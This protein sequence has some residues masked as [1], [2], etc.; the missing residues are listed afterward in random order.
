MKAEK[1]GVSICTARL[2]EP[3]RGSEVV[4]KLTEGPKNRYEAFVEP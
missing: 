4:A 1:L 3:F 2:W